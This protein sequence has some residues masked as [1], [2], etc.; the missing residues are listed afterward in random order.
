MKMLLCYI[1]RRQSHLEKGSSGNTD[2]I[3]AVRFLMQYFLT[4]DRSRRNPNLCASSSAYSPKLDPS[5]RD[6]SIS[7]RGWSMHSGGHLSAWS[8]PVT[9]RNYGMRSQPRV[10]LSL[11][12]ATIIA[13]FITCGAGNHAKCC[14][15]S[16]MGMNRCP[17]PMFTRSV[18]LH[19][20]PFC[21]P[22]IFPFCS[23][24]NT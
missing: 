19:G 2:L 3:S 5:S 8:P 9:P 14:R 10:Q 11:F 7:G 15:A 1:S 21:S 13:H 4:F 24:R 16:K 17:K 18:G 22:E 6:A 20:V 12:H 23:P